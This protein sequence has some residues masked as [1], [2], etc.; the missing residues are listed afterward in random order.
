MAQLPKTRAMTDMT[1]K[2]EPNVH[3]DDSTIV[4]VMQGNCFGTSFHPELSTDARIHKWWLERVVE[5]LG[6]KAT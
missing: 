1:T 6:T 4:A 2:G 5:S 3:A